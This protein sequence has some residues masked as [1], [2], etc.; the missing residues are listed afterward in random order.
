M[1][2]SPPM[3]TISENVDSEVKSPDPSKGKGTELASDVFE[4][5]RK[6]Y[7]AE[8]KTL[9]GYFSQIGDLQSKIIEQQA[10]VHNKFQELTA[11]NNQIL[12]HRI[13]ELENKSG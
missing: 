2:D 5:L 4:R 1:T 13:K 3:P 11:L 7:S 8:K 6:E 10:I 12:L 9:E